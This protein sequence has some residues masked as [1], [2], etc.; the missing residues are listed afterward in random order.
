MRRRPMPRRC[1][2]ASAAR[3]HWPLAGRVADGLVLAEAAGPTYVAQSIDTRRSVPIRSGY[4]SSPQW[5]STTMLASARRVMAP[6]VAGLLDGTNPAPLAHP[7][8]DEILERHAARG[9]DGIA[10]MP[11]DWWIEFGAIGSF[12]DAV[13]H[14]EALADAGADDVTFF[15]GPSVELAREDL[16]H[17]VRLAAALH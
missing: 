2:P 1:S 17:V 12:D 4:R 3:S 7:H 16:D 14:A 5:R 9:L 10:D 15:P 6:F 13:R 8:I 11:A